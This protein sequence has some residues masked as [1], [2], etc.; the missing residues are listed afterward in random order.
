MTKKITTLTLLGMVATSGVSL[1]HRFGS[2]PED[3]TPPIL[4]Y[5][6][7]VQSMK[8]DFGTAAPVLRGVF[9]QLSLWPASKTLMACFYDGEPALRAF[10]IRSA[11]KW[12]PGTSLKVDFGSEPTYRTCEQDVLDIRIAFSQ[13]GYWSYMGTD[14]LNP[15]VIKKGASLNI[16]TDSHPFN[17][18]NLQWIDEAITH[19]FGHALGLLH[20]HQSPAAHCGD[21]FDWE[22]INAFAKEKW[23]WTA[24]EVHTNFAPYVDDPRLR[25]TP[26]DRDSVMHYALAD[27]MFKKGKKSKCYVSEPRTMSNE[28]KIT[29]A[30]AYPPVTAMQG[31]ELQKRATTI[32]G[33]MSQLQLNARQLAKAG[34]SLG[35]RMKHYNRKVHLEFALTS[36][37]MVRGASPDTMN[38]CEGNDIKLSSAPAVTCGVAPDG[39]GLVLDVNP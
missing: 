17:S 31:K 9:N 26:Y 20:E 23:G 21:E 14:S 3:L 13:K 18:L 15:D 7:D 5:A 34:M 16:Q 39:S 1:A 6:E 28:D 12:L 10:F 35:A 11:Q 25:T 4:A 8:N 2:G 24:E 29:I 27:W 30:D 22:K 32:A 19:E 37:S 36:S 33:V 38:P